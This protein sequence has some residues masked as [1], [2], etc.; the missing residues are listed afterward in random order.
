M[1]TSNHAPLAT[2]RPLRPS[3]GRPH[4]TAGPITA[5]PITAGPITAGPITSGPGRYQ[6]G[7]R[8][9]I[10]SGPRKATP[11]VHLNEVVQVVQVLSTTRTYAYTRV[12]ARA[13]DSSIFL[14]I[15]LTLG[16]LGP[17]FNINPLAWDQRLD[18]LV[19]PGPLTN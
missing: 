9:K 2:R 8:L 7:T 4:I 16:P 11:L 10:Q 17:A 19:P 13:H 14:F 1:T 6:P 18:R 3:N 12:R 15:G 5:G